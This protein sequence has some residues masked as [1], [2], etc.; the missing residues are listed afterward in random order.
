MNMSDLSVGCPIAWKGTEAART[1]TAGQMREQ[2]SSVVGLADLM[3]NDCDY[4]F[5]S[6]ITMCLPYLKA[7]TTTSTHFTFNTRTRH[8]CRPFQMPKF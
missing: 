3:V 8:S 2:E 5:Q 6:N 1:D 4:L 7:P